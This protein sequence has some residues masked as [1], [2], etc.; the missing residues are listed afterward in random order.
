MPDG[1]KEPSRAA[2]RTKSAFFSYGDSK[3]TRGRLVIVST[4]MMGTRTF[5]L[6][7]ILIQVKE[8]GEYE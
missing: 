6:R 2:I 3:R 4:H 5:P 1:N 7:Y 8:L